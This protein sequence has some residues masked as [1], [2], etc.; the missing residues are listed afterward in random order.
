MS[1]L[2]RIFGAARNVVEMHGDIDR[3]ARTIEGH[4]VE[5]K[6]HERRLIRIE[7]MIEMGGS[8]PP[9]PRRLTRS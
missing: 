1:I 4:A 6:D 7:T 9:P 5:L 3:A 2:D 8:R